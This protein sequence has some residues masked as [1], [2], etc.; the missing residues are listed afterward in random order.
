MFV[1]ERPV[2]FADV[3]AAR[4]VFFARHLEYCHD[5]LEALFAPLPGGYAAMINTREVGVPSV[6]VEVEYHAPLRYGDTVRIETDVVRLGTKSVSFRH[7][8]RR[9]ADGT[10]CATV[11]QVVVFSDLRSLRP[12]A[13]PDEVRALLAG[14]LAA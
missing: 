8:L 6:K 12:I 9:G 7:A 14:H 11:L 4:I 2:R 10:C 1:F 3:D 13:I 5:A